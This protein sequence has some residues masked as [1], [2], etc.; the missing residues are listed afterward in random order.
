MIFVA[1]I[2]KQKETENEPGTKGSCVTILF[3]G[4]GWNE[5]SN[6]NIIHTVRGNLW[7]Y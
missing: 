1:D 3:D 5:S 7:L 4:P 6:W 2:E